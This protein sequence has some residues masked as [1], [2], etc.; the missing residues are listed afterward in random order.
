MKTTSIYILSVLLAL[1]LDATEARKRQKGRIGSGM[2]KYRRKGDT[3]KDVLTLNDRKLGDASGRCQLKGV[4][5][6]VKTSKKGK[7]RCTC[8]IMKRRNMSKK[9]PNRKNRRARNRRKKIL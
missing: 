9:R 7:P 5:C 6:E 2:C 4:S 1:T 8:K 3:C